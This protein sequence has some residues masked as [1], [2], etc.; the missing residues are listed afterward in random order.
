MANMDTIATMLISK[1]IM[2][3]ISVFF[4]LVTLYIYYIIPDLRETQDKVTSA[5]VG[6]LA[7]FMFLLSLVQ[8]W[9]SLTHTPFC[10][11]I[12]RSTRFTVTLPRRNE[13]ENEPPPSQTVPPGQYARGKRKRNKR[14][15]GRKFYASSLCAPSSNRLGSV[16]WKPIGACKV[17]R[18]VAV[19][20]PLETV[21]VGFCSFVFLLAIVRFSIFI[22]QTYFKFYVLLP[23]RSISTDRRGMEYFS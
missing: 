16:N 12:G 14:A 11:V 21:S 15:C 7:V 4:L 20:K 1:G 3:L 10:T 13:V 17:H 22:A 8:L 2:M 9:V 6:S 19:R 23:D 5:A 18:F